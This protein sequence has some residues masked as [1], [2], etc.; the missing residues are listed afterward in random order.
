MK[1]ALFSHNITEDHKEKLRSFFSKPLEQVKFLYITTPTNYKPFKP[2]W[3]VESENRW[4][5]IFPMLREFDLERAYKVDPTFDFAKYIAEFDFVFISG[6]NTFI[7]SYWMKKTGVVKIIQNLVNSD[8]LVYGGESAGAIFAY[9]EIDSYKRLDDPEKAIDVV[10]EG[11]AFVNFAPIPH[12]ENQ[13][14][15]SGLKEIKSAFE[16]RGVVTYTI[17]D[18]EALFVTD[19]QVVKL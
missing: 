6:G 18:N 11:L 2:E 15:R 7:L 5:S 16:A 4:R 14:F 19:G 9:S 10:N 13:E 12:W 17:T 3:C 8:R 1:L